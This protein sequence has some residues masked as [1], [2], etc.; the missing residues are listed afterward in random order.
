[1]NSMLPKAALA[2][3]LTVTA[4]VSFAQDVPA[5][6]VMP[7]EEMME[8]PAPRPKMKRRGRIQNK[9]HMQNMMRMMQM[10]R[11]MPA[12]RFSAETHAAVKAYRENPNE[13]NKAALRQ[14]LEKNFDTM[15]A[16]RKAKLDEMVAK[17]DETITK[18]LEHMTAPKP[19]DDDSGELRGP[20]APRGPRP[21]QGVKA[22]KGP[23]GPK[24]MKGC[25][26]CKDDAAAPASSR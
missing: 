13:E 2:M 5:P 19:A 24:E 6:E 21:L 12:P 8:Q 16:E 11:Q 3:A 18:Q 1:M 17:R 20:R 25:P 22:P 4:C 14:Q 9:E 15:V 7:Q 26:S 10:Q 23:K